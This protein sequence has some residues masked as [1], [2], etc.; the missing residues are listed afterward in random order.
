MNE[1]EIDEGMITTGID[2]FIKL[3]YDRRRVE[4][5]E[6]SKSLGIPSGT[7]EY[8]SYVLEGEGLVKINYTM[9]AVF[10]EWAGS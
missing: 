10:L 3:L 5:G 7:I 6:A 2:R 4:L 1:E 9:T 8:W